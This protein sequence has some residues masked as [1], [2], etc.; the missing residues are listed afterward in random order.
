[1][2]RG[3]QHRLS[4]TNDQFSELIVEFFLPL[5]FPTP[6]SKRGAHCFEGSP[7]LP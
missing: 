1:M 3:N 2:F 6:G 7:A 4:T 5:H